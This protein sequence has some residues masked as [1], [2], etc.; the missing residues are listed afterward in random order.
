MDTTTEP[1]PASWGCYGA[2]RSTTAVTITKYGA[3]WRW[4]KTQASP[5]DVQGTSAGAR[6]RVQEMGR[7]FFYRRLWRVQR[8]GCVAPGGFHNYQSRVSVFPEQ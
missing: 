5:E 6:E 2:R 7:H 8:A 1:A 3:A 4:T